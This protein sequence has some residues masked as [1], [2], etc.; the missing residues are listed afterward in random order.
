MT[1]L[2]SF[3]NEEGGIDLQAFEKR[4]H[5]NL[6]NDGDGTTT[7][8]IETIAKK[9][10]LVNFKCVMRDELKGKKPKNNECGIINLNTSRENGSHWCCWYKNGNNKY[11]FDSFGTVPPKEIIKYL[12][13]PI[14]YS[15]YQIQQFNDTN[16]GEWCLYVLKELNSGKNFT[17]VVLDIINE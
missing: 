16:C 17:D 3:A 12:G 11:Y 7:R 1:D 2:R 15:T 10:K 4:K 8:E 14:M 9:L 5:V 13:S 6:Q